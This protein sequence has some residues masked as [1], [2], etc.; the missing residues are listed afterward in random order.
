MD[1]DASVRENVEIREKIWSSFGHFEIM[2]VM[3]LEINN[4]AHQNR[5]MPK[6]WK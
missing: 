5:D 1:E 2:I 6:P 4:M 3:C